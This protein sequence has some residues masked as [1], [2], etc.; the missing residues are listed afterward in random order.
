MG[1]V[2]GTPAAPSSSMLRLAKP[3]L[4]SFS[5]E[6]RP[7]AGQHDAAASGIPLRDSS[8]V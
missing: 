7:K 5:V 3:R 6:H 8:L 2:A 1:G 4:A